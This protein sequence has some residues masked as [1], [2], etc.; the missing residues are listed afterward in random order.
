MHSADIRGAAWRSSSF[1]FSR[2]CV[3]SE[4]PSLK[5]LPSVLPTKLNLHCP[6]YQSN[7][8]TNPVFQLTVMRC[9]RTAARC[10]GLRIA[11]LGVVLW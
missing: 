4:T 3:N 7:V 9:H 2:I 10:Q 11:L 5:A 1:S 6:F 8:R